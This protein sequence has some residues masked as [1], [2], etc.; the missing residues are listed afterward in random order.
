MFLLSAVDHF[1]HLSF[2]AASHLEVL[3]VPGVE[4]AFKPLARDLTCSECLVHLLWEQPRGQRSTL[5]IFADLPA[6]KSSP[7][8]ALQIALGRSWCF[9][10]SGS[11]Q[12]CILTA[13]LPFVG[14]DRVA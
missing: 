1:L 4:P 11:L 5:S 8:T 10:C 14:V 9:A 6:S 3:T 12:W 13:V 7:C 2:W